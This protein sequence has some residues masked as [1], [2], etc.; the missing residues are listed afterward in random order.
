M[1]YLLHVCLITVMIFSFGFCSKK[2]AGKSNLSDEISE[3]IEK[4]ELDPAQPHSN[5]Y[6]RVLARYKTNKYNHLLHL[7]YEW[8]VNGK[9]V[10]EVHSKLLN[11][12][13]FKKKDAV[14]CTVSIVQGKKILNKI[15]TRKIKI[16]NSPPKILEKPLPKVKVPG[17]MLYQIEASDPDG[18]EL[19]Y[20]LVYPLDLGI[21][22][23]IK[24]GL[25]TWTINDDTLALIEARKVAE[26]E[27]DAQNSSERETQA[28]MPLAIQFQVSDG[29][30]G[31]ALGKINFE[32][33]RRKGKPVLKLKDEV[34]Q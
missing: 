24:N 8:R 14:Q 5:S 20:K 11:R 30:G 31:L 21:D 3:V 23:D 9:V 34:R 29:D 33:T 25:M 19:E 27:A 12:K 17:M 1:K 26:E 10:S 22:L 7:K 4:L 13:Y 16:A 28:V 6:V 15:K 18:D 2:K 32:Y